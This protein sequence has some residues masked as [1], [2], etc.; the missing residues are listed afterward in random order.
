MD[1][2]VVRCPD[3]GQLEWWARQELEDHGLCRTRGGE[4][5]CGNNSLH[6]VEEASS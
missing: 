2:Q 3:C 4:C 6:L 5:W 1:W